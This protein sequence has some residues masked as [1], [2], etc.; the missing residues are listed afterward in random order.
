M[1]A[2]KSLFSDTAPTFDEVMSAWGGDQKYLTRRQIAEALGRSK[3]PALIAIIGV[4]VGMGYLATRTYMLP[5]NVP[6]FEYIPTQ[7]WFDDGNVSF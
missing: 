1:N 5:N 4:L 3:S 7:K 6:M 2:Q